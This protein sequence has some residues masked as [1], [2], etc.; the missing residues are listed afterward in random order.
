MELKEKELKK[1][2]IAKRKII[3]NKLNLLKHGEIVKERAFL[4]ITKHLKNIHKELKDNKTK[5]IKD[6]MNDDI[7]D[8]NLYDTSENLEDNNADI[9]GLKRSI[10]KNIEDDEDNEDDDDNIEI[11][12]DKLS[13]T[14]EYNPLIKRYIIG[15]KQHDKNDYDQIYGIRL[16]NNTKKLSIGD[17][18][19]D[20]KGSDIFIKNRRYKGTIGLFELLFK[21]KPKLFT[22]QD[23]QNY[24]EIVLNTNAHRRLYQSNKQ[25]AGN[26]SG[27]YKNIIAPIT[28]GNGLFME[29]NNNKI[30]HVYWDDPNELVE[31]LRLILAET[32]AGHTGHTNDIISIIEELK[33][34]K[35]I[36]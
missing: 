13:N 4:P 17:S 9:S 16:D 6:D 29:V 12:T 14:V 36:Y 32:K 22:R 25:I 27:K 21:K 8:D 3:K 35:I 10:I 1:Q 30:D 7:N 15:L 34:A 26:R 23:E 11:K 31:R 24:Q 2:L 33:E 5:E 18:E 19:V 28:Q 20:I